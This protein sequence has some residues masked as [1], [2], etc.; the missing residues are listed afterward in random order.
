MAAAA[1][2]NGFLSPKDSGRLAGLTPD[3][4]E[5]D[6][7]DEDQHYS[8]IMDHCG[9]LFGRAIIIRWHLGEN[10]K[11]GGPAGCGGC[12]TPLL[13]LLVP[14][15]LSAKSSTSLGDFHCHPSGVGEATKTS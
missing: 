4:E 14:P 6:D 5:D 11:S 1:V 3:E 8:T 10:K 15:S 2:R 9:P 7:D 13:L 12:H